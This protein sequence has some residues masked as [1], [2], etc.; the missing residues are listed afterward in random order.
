MNKDIN[1][2]PLSSKKLGKGHFLHNFNQIYLIIQY[3]LEIIKKL[4]KKVG[5]TS[6]G[7]EGEKKAL[8]FAADYRKVI[9]LR[10]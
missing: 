5:R 8:A 2:E 1:N 3:F 10:K 4:R 9:G 7:D 6:E